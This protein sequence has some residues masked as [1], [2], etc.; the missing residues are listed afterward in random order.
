MHKCPICEKFIE[1]ARD[2]FTYGIAE[3]KSCRFDMAPKNLPESS[4]AY[5]IHEVCADAFRQRVESGETF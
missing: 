5:Q 4:R 2:Q 3:G 1:P